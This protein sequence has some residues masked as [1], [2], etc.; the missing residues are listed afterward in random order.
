MLIYNSTIEG[1]VDTTG[2]TG[3][4]CPLLAEFKAV[5]TGSAGAP[6]RAFSSRA[7]RWSTL[8]SDM[9]RVFTEDDPADLQFLRK[10]D[11]V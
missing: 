10:F 2:G 8:C 1:V 3:E 4:K 6:P 9:H 7:W 5:Q 11:K